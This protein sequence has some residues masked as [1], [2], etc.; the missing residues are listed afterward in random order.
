MNWSKDAPTI[1]G[2]YWFKTPRTGTIRAFKIIFV[3]QFKDALNPTGMMVAD[4]FNGYNLLRDYEGYEF[5]PVT[6]PP[7]SN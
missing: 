3:E 7:E 1:P 4:V 6:D 2:Y 5:A